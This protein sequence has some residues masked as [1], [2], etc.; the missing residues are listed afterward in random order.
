M[1]EEFGSII[2]NRFPLLREQ[3]FLLAC[4]GGVDSM[5][6]AHLCHRSNL[7]F[8]LAHCNFGL[9]GAESDADEELVRAL[10]HKLHLIVYVTRFDTIG[11]TNKHK[12]S[13]E[14]AARELRYTWF[15]KIMGEGQ[16]GTLVTAHHAD[17][18]LETFLINLSR[19]TGIDGLLGIPEKKDKIIRPLLQFSREQIMEFAEEEGI[20]WREDKSNLDTIH[21][22]NKIR[23]QIVPILKELHPTF[24]R[25]FKNTQEYLSQSA[26]IASDRIEYLKTK[27]FQKEGG[28]VK[29]R[30]DS[31]MAL[32]P[33]G[34]YLHSLFKNYGFTE[35]NDV[36]GLLTANSGK[37][38]RSNTHRLVKDRAHLLLQAIKQRTDFEFKIPEG[39]NLLKEPISISLETVPTMGETS[40]NS[41]FVDKDLLNFPLIVRKWRKGDWFR[42]FGMKGV[43][44]VSKFFKDE[45]MDLI[46][47][48]EQWLLIS[49]EDIVWI[50]GRRGDDRFRITEDTR[51]I[52]KIGLHQ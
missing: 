19:G 28:V 49:G 1:L 48:E 14:M 52:L 3:P 4:S 7:Q 42:P 44:K 37:E 38:V 18:N 24:L 26:G 15:D 27:L 17:D 31:L 8:S 32:N 5:V 23:H 21:L 29:V 47:K 9:R 13:I 40:K 25:N 2:E 6:L 43:K 41:I 20:V 16:L 35:W 50:I 12:V 45:K 22:R 33:V 51:Q 10:A 36:A 11:Y 34:A 46:A 39:E 30:I